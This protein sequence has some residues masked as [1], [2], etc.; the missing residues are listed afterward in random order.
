MPVDPAK[1]KQR[2]KEGGYN[3]IKPIGKGN[4]ATVWECQTIVPA[5][6]EGEQPRVV[7]AKIIDL[8]FLRFHKNS[9]AEIA[10]IKR[11]V[12]ILQKLRHPNIVR[13]E[14][15]LLVGSE[16]LILVMEHVPGKE[17]FLSL[18]HI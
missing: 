1:F 5:T 6:R 7:A 15:T 14:K 10:R 12:T 17:L 4:Y 3:A 11:E 18:I 9:K 2:L 16:A 13:L 8:S